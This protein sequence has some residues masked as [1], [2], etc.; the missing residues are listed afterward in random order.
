MVV[1]EATAHLDSLSEIRCLDP[2][3]GSVFF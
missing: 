3:C 2:A 1:D